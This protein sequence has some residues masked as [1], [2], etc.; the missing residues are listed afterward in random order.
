MVTALAFMLLF[1]MFAFVLFLVFA[2]FFLHILAE[3]EI[4]T[5]WTVGVVE[6]TT[7]DFFSVSAAVF[8]ESACFLFRRF[9]NIIL[10]IRLCICSYQGPPFQE[11]P[12]RT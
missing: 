6:R 7:L 12:N 2:L 3:S 5:K 11:A 8:D 9:D 1:L 4:C 10:V